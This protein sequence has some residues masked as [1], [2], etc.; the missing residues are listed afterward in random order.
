[1]AGKKLSK[2][3]SKAKAASAPKKT[4]A[5][6]LSADM[7]RLVPTG[8]GT[9]Y[10]YVLNSDGKSIHSPV[11]SEKFFEAIMSLQG[12]NVA[13]RVAKHAEQLEELQPECGWLKAAALLRGEG[14]PS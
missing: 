7:P 8:A 14:E 11:G 13:E 1:M 3:A 10:A 5:I 4:G 6:E 9:P 12:T 2:T